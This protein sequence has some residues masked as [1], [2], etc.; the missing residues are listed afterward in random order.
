MELLVAVVL[1]S[2][3]AMQ[4]LHSAITSSKTVNSAKRDSVASQL[5]LEKL[6]ELSLINPEL[7]NDDYDETESL[8]ENGIPYTRATDITINPDRSRQVDIDVS[9]TNNIRG[10]T[11]S[12]SIAFHLWGSR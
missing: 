3:L 11:S 5:A 10:G 1:G 4:I 8:Y 6:E 7:L 12:L 9:A 2:I